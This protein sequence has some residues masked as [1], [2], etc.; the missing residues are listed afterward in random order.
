LVETP[1]LSIQQ[2]A[3]DT[4]NGK[5]SLQKR[6]TDWQ[7][8]EPQSIPADSAAV[9]DLL[10]ALTGLKATSFVEDPSEQADAMKGNPPVTS[11]SFSTVV[12]STQPSTQPSSAPAMTTVTFGAYDDV[13]KKHVYAK[14]TSSPFIAKVDTTAMNAFNKKPIDL[15]DKRVIN[16]P[17]EEVSR[18][19]ITGDVPAATQPTS[20]PA[21]KTEITIVRRGAGG[22]GVPFAPTTSPSTAPAVAKN[23]ELPNAKKESP[24]V[25]ADGTDVD[26]SEVREFLTAMYPLKADKYLESNPAATQPSAS[27]YTVSMHTEAA[28]G[29]KAADYIVTL[30]DRGNDQPLIGDYNGLTFEAPRFTLSRFLEGDFK[31]KGGSGPAAPPP[32]LPLGNP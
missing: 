14:V 1:S 11:I 31:N 29:A 3:I 25:K 10:N 23:F 5:L 20:R 13:L 6:G 19:T 2:L 22:K 4:K 7:I 16:V 28:G 9:T 21:K 17:A 8:T 26:E 27:R 15:R 30:M 18:F 24:W 12:A 32:G